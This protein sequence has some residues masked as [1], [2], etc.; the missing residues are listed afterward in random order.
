[1]KSCF[2]VKILYYYIMFC[3]ECIVYLYIL[4]F[5]IVF[6]LLQEDFPNGQVYG[7]NLFLREIPLP[8]LMYFRRICTPVFICIGISYGVLH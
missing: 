4:G 1:M 6:S 3:F 5:F 7:G 8:A 2:F